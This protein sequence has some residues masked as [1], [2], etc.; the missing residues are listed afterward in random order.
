MCGK[1][2]CRCLLNIGS[3]KAFTA[4][5]VATTRGEYIEDSA[6]DDA[7]TTGV[8]SLVWATTLAC[9]GGALVGVASFLETPWNSLPS[10]LCRFAKQSST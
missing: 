6:V 2:F 7:I 8:P 10:N 5:R 3:G 4:L 1:N 9:A